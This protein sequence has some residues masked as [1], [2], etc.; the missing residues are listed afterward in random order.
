MTLAFA[1][2]PLAG[3]D[4]ASPRLHAERDLADVWQ[5]LRDED[6]VVWHPAGAGGFW[7]VTRH[8]H[9]LAVYRDS[10]TYTSKRGNVLATLLAG[11]DPAGGQMLVVSDGPR[12]LE[13]RRRLL[14]AFTPA[15]LR[16]LSE[17]IARST[18][19]LVQAAAARS[20]CE[21]SADVAEH[22]PL[23]AICDLLTIPEPDRRPLLAHAR[24]CLAAESADATDT[25]ARLARNEILMYFARLAMRRKNVP[26]DDVFAIL[27]QLTREPLAL[28]QQELLLNSYSLLLGGDETSRLSLVGTIKA[29]ADFPDEWQRLRRGEVP[30]DSAVEELLRWTTPAMHSGRTATVAHELAGK[31]IAAGHT[32]TVWN[33]AANFDPAEFAEPHR[34]DLGRRPNRHLAFGHGHHFCLGAQLA[35]IELSALLQALLATTERIE[36]TGEP[37]RLYSNFL[38]G[39]GKLPVRLH[40]RAA[41]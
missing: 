5:L 9:A 29:L 1:T 13:I 24:A 30:V 18:V 33:S 41:T 36:L 23:A 27:L 7:V 8:A 35:R 31:S 37:R 17:R 6:P 22:I 21:F 20:E 28:S 15:A 10:D 12:N 19:A 39:Y 34:L 26:G 32:V 40:P 3:I 2:G 11:G 25:D 16:D 38:G 4:L 14:R